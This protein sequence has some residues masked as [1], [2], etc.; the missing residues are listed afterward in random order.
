MRRS[1]RKR[2]PTGPP[3]V[4]VRG[5]SRAGQEIGSGLFAKQRIP[6]GTAVASFPAVELDTDSQIKHLERGFPHDSVVHVEGGGR[7]R[8]YKDGSWKDPAE[9]PDWYRMNDP[10][11]FG[12]GKT[13]NKPN[14][15]P[16]WKQGR[17]EFVAAPKPIE[18]GNELTWS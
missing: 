11:V 9:I 17:V 10:Q 4:Q 8:T 13:V 3:T 14:T 1:K 15:R 16:V 12:S 6:R 2:G 5:A 18:Q 7:S